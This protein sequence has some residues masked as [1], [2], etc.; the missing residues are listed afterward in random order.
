MNKD[1]MRNLLDEISLCLIGSDYCEQCGTVEG[2]GCSQ[3]GQ[4]HFLMSQRAS[5]SDS[6]MEPWRA[7]ELAL[8]WQ[9]RG[10]P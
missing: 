8:Q 4:C 9:N 5:S 10:K 7:K 2:A 3:E 6:I 1:E